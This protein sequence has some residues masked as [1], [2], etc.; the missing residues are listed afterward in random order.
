MVEVLF[1]LS[2]RT[3][4]D[5][6]M[7]YT[8]D[9]MCLTVSVSDTDTVQHVKEKYAKHA[10]CSPEDI[11]ITY[12]EIDL[13][14]D[15]HHMQKH[16]IAPG[17][18]HLVSL[19]QGQHPITGE[20]VVILAAVT[21]KHSP[22]V[23]CITVASHDKPTHPDLVIQTIRLSCESHRYDP[24]KE[25][26]YAGFILYAWENE[27]GEVLE[28]WRLNGKHC[29]SAYLVIQGTDS[30][31][32]KR[33][34]GKAPGQV[35]GAVYWNVFGKGADVSKAVGEGFAI[36]NEKYK[37]NSLTFNAKG[38][39]YHAKKREISA[40]AQKC[41]KQIEDDWKRTSPVGKTYSVEKLLSSKNT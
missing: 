11:H 16:G 24:S 7:A 10:G 17:D 2:V 1:C 15:H 27:H 9:G 4:I 20:D 34:T 6:D 23:D 36:V 38:D 32:V 12:S 41:V 39:A 14:H 31:D 25:H 18:L 22:R 35:H 33:Y 29:K 5:L 26:N 21:T 30:P 3:T 19:G 8:D 13:H 37:W 40:L 28:D